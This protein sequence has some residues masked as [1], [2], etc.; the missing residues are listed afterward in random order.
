MSDESKYSKVL[1]RVNKY[2]NK[3]V[4]AK[5]TVDAAE[6]NQAV[7][8]TDHFIK[9]KESNIPEKL[10]DV[11]GLIVKLYD[12][13]LAVKDGEFKLEKKELIIAFIALAYVVSPLD[14][15]P[16]FILLFGFM[17]DAMIVSYA[18]KLLSDAVNRFDK[19][20]TAEL[21]EK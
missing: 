5:K 19:W 18:V 16:D 8:E 11:W 15:I 21:V 20:K 12:M 10:K 13:I 9:E 14:L 6:V 17:D 7:K 1:A 4:K 3:A 2:F